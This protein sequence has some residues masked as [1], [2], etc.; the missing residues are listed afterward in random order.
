MRILHVYKDFAP[1]GGGGGV[2]RHIHGLAVTLVNAGHTLRILAPLA[3]GGISPHGYAVVR[4]SAWHLWHHV[5]WADVVHVHGART[6]IAAIAGALARLRGRRLIYTPHCYYDDDLAVSKRARKWCWDRLVEKLLLR[7]AHPTVLLSAYWLD[8]LSRRQLPPRR[9]LLLPNAVLAAEQ[10]L[11]AT[12]RHALRGT[13]ALLSVGRLDAV[14]RLQ[15]AIAAL[16]QPGM[17]AAV[18]HVVGRGPD[19]ARLE[20]CA[21]ALGVAAR[22]HFHGFVNDA[23]VAAMAAQADVFVLPSAVEGMPTVLIEML[24]HGCP[25]VASDIPGNRSILA[26]IG[27]QEALH[28]LGDSAALAACIGVQRQ[29]RIGQERIARVQADFTWEGLRAQVL[30]LY[31]A[32]VAQEPAP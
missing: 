7:S 6:P 2:A 17:D 10:C 21:V 25:V 28:R 3:D 16:T 5:G 29:Q 27:L 19:R 23:D 32:Q 20:A 24:L 13:P 22:V 18:L 11:P 8:Y 14:K 31:D 4:A 1:H 15:D 30:A 12:P 9:A 26:Q